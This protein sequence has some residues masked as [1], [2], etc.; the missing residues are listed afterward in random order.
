MS[1]DQIRILVDADA[2][3]VKQEIYACAYRL[4][5]PAVLVA[6]TYLRHPNHPLISMQVVSDGFDAADDWIVENCERGVLVVTTDIL[7]AERALRNNA[8]VIQPNGRVLTQ[9]NIGS[10]VA[11]R[12][13]QS[14]LRAGL[15]QTS[16]PPPFSKQD[17][18]KFVNTLDRNM[19]AL[20]RAHRDVS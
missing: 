15:E 7:L 14:E 11:T 2:C 13:L 16:G 20:I 4:N 18:V 19:T 5:I 3:P 1:V 6:N 17:R 8:M 10:A 9:D 12:N